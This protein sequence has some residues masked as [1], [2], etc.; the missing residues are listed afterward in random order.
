MKKLFAILMIA[1]VAIANAAEVVEIRSFAA[2]EFNAPRGGKLARVEVF[3]TNATG[4][5]NLKSVYSAPVFTNAVQIETFAATNVTV[6]SSNR[7]WR[8]AS[9]NDVIPLATNAYEAAGFSF[10]MWQ[11]THPLDALVSSNRTV[12]VTATTNRW[13]VYKG[14]VAVTNSIISGGSLSGSKYGGAP[15]GDTWLAPGERLIYTG[16]GG[17]FLRLILE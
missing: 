9:T 2:G 8:A 4:T 5:V 1:L 10:A 13:P 12:T 3:S 7:L 16:P 15:G 6:V 17:G 14:E 11:R